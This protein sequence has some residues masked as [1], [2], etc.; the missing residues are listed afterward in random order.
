MGAD[1]WRGKAL[2][3]LHAFIILNFLAEIA[4]ASWMIFE[5]LQ[6]EGPGPLGARALT[7]DHEWMVTRR[8]YAI[9]CWIA[10][11]GLSVYL[12]I[13]EIGPRL[14]DARASGDAPR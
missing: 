9:E 6:P 5:V 13:T 4:Y 11:A 10:I 7:L 12:A 1:G 14:R 3:A 2:L 8:L